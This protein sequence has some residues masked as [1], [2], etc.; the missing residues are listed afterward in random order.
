MGRTPTDNA[1]STRRIADRSFEL[2]IAISHWQYS[3]G[4][5]GNGSC[6]GSGHE[7]VVTS[8]AT[9][10]VGGSFFREVPVLKQMCKNRCVHSVTSVLPPQQS[11]IQ[12]SPNNMLKTKIYLAVCLLASFLASG[13]MVV[14]PWWDNPG[15]PL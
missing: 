9:R 14:G 10:H 5:S 7:G 13:G 2:K 11:D 4:R 1:Q 8:D 6:L 12:S 15:M 3:I